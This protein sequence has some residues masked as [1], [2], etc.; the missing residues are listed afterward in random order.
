MGV[1]VVDLLRDR[2]TVSN[3]RLAHLN[4][5]IMCATQNVD[6]NVQVQFAHALDQRLARIFIGSN[7]E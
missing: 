5:N 4:V 7:L 6:L 2:F 1:R 3:L